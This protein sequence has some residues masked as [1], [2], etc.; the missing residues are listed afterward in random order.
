MTGVT[1]TLT[2]TTFCEG[3]VVEKNT[4]QYTVFMALQTYTTTPLDN[5]ELWEGNRS[6][7][8]KINVC[9]GLHIKHLRGLLNVFIY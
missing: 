1:G 4:K 8:M 6:K 7:V 2:Y 3:V 9:D 5:V